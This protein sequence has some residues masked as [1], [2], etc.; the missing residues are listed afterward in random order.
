[1]GWEPAAEWDLP[2]RKL[3]RCGRNEIAPV[4]IKQFERSSMHFEMGKPFPREVHA[5][6]ETSTFRAWRCSDDREK[7]LR[8][9]I[10][11]LVEWKR[12]VTKR[13]WRSAR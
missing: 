10:E 11:R 7:T 13:K 5:S 12:R 9:L 2:S 3:R 1:M 4:P 6:A 8:E